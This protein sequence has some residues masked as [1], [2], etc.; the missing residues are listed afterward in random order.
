[1]QDD[2]EIELR[3][4]NLTMGGRNS[5]RANNCESRQKVAI[6]V[7][8]RNRSSS[9]RKF[10]RHMHRFL[11]KQLVEYAIFV[12]EP[13]ENITFNRG[14]LMNIGFTEAIKQNPKWNCFIFHDVD[15]YPENEN[16]LYLCSKIYVRHMSS[17][18]NIFD[19]KYGILKSLI[20]HK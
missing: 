16:N 14:L 4:L 15:L 8:Y 5:P 3:Y 9:L 2:L 6:V 12:V 1:M 7:P 13:V 10:L 19:Y 17:S 18:I 20:H 11:T